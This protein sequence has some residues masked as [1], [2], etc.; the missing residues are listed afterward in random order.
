MSSRHDRGHGH[1][2]RDHYRNP[3]AFKAYVARLEGATRA[4]WQ[5]PVAVVRA[6]GIRPGQTVAEIG[7]GPGY[8]TFRLAKAVGKK[9]RVLAA[10]V[11]PKMLE[12]LRHRLERQRVTNVTPILGSQDDP[13]LPEGL[14]DQILIVNTFHHF[15]AG[16]A[17]LRGLKRYL[18]PRGRLV[19][20]DFHDRPRPVGPP[21]S[22]TVS[23]DELVAVAKGAGYAVLA[24]HAFLEY[25][26]FLVLAPHAAV[27][28]RRRRS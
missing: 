6:L 7:A 8:F 24:E 18:K 9:G 21:V 15:A 13:R 3:T 27:S 5:K 1:R 17:Y 19:T 12:I 22:E 4:R 26:Y 2:H 28:G 23:R 16:E 14:A 10:E 20:I 25:Q 11:E